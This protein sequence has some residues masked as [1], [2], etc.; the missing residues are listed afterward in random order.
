M[1]GFVLLMS[2]CSSGGGGGDGG[3]G[4]G[5]ASAPYERPDNTAPY[6]TTSSPGG[7]GVGI[8]SPIVV[9]FN[10]GMKESTLNNDSVK[11]WNGTSFITFTISHSGVVYTFTPS[12]PLEYAKTYTVTIK[13]DTQDL[14]GNSLGGDYTFQFTTMS[15]PA[16]EINIKQQSFGDLPIG[17]GNYGFGAIVSG[18]SSSAVSFTIEN[19]GSANLTISN[20]VKNGANH[21]QFTIDTSGMNNS[22]AGGGTSSFTVQFNPTSTGVKTAVITVANND[23]DETNYTF[24][25]TGTGTATPEPEI[26]LKKGVTD[27]SSGAQG[28]D[29]GGVIVSQSSS[30]V[31]FTIENTGPAN[32][33]ISNVTINSDQF[34]L[35]ASSLDNDLSQNE[36]TTFTVTFNPTSTGNKTATVTVANNDTDEGSYAF[37][38]AGTGNPSPAPEINVKKDSN[39][40][41]SGGSIDFGSSAINGSIIITITIQ[42]LGSADLILSGTPK[43]EITGTDASQFQVD[44]QPISPITP[45]GN[46]TCTIVFQPTSVGSKSAIVRIVNNDGDEGT[47]TLTIAGRGR[48][49]SMVKDISPG[50]ASSSIRFMGRI[51][52]TV[53]FL[54]ANSGLWKT[55]GTEVGTILLKNI[56]SNFNGVIFNGDLYLP[57]YSG[58]GPYHD[59]WKSDGT[60]SGTVLVKDINPSGDGGIHSD[61]LIAGNYICF[62]ASD[63]PGGGNQEFW[64][65]NGTGDGTFV[66]DCNTD[67]IAW[68]TISSDPIILGTSGTSL[69]FT[70]SRRKEVYPFDRELYTFNNG[71][72]TRTEFTPGDASSSITTLGMSNG[73]LYLGITNGTTN[74]YSVKVADGG[75]IY[76]FGLAYALNPIFCNN[77]YWVRSYSPT[78][79]GELYT[80]S[81]FYTS[82]S[83]VKDIYPGADIDSTPQGITEMGGKVY[84]TAIDALHGR[85]LWCSDGTTAGTVLVKDINSGSTSGPSGYLYNVNGVLVFIA[86]DGIHGAELWKSDGT[87]GGTQLLLDIK[88]GTGSSNISNMFTSNGKLYFTA[89]DGIH[90]VELWST[91]G[92]SSGTFLVMDIFPGNS[93]SSPQS[94]YNAGGVIYFTADNGTHG[95]ELWM[96]E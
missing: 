95:T 77:R 70:A 75:S 10:E 35:N 27:I 17:S 53:F 93:S 29:F 37:T 8:N 38:V 36:T 87:E 16:P 65:S 3:G 39:D 18:G 4:G 49:C 56:S 73:K 66:E 48:G 43:V 80:S 58:G 32:L 2:A 67:D 15:A 9:A 90:G 14:S 1:I 71:S 78:T 25:V 44:M 84:F 33:A 79:G 26:N 6:V 34:T 23:A 82:F 24:Y 52:N 28:H 69:Y 91:D 31:T 88:H 20:V 41:V 46:S 63:T 54:V 60:T 68:R 40:I 85:E 86:D 64:Y 30:T 76:S 50:I 22:I 45:G 74:G 89:D 96:L 72:I 47:Y 62:L 61:L 59:L 19:L 7:A 42:N 51:N 13:K 83:L 12:N 21:D 55:D 81:S 92:T 5:G 94:F 11:I 57:A